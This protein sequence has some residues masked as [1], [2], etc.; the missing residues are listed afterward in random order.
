MTDSAATLSFSSS[1]WVKKSEAE[2]YQACHWVSQYPCKSFSLYFTWTRGSSSSPSSSSSEYSSPLYE[3]PSAISK[4]DAKQSKG[5]SI[6]QNCRSNQW[7]VR[8]FGNVRQI[9]GICRRY[10]GWKTAVQNICLH[11]WLF[12]FFGSLHFVSEDGKVGVWKASY[13]CN[14]TKTWIYGR[15][16]IYTRCIRFVEEKGRKKLRRFSNILWGFLRAKKRN[17]IHTLRG[18]ISPC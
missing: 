15:L 17:Y 3:F 12:W 9:V 14:K 18:Y 4:T 5:T 13:Y 7:H 1:S 16:V 6:A 8:V 10:E 2:I 11:L